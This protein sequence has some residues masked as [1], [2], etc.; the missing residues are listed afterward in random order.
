MKNLNYFNP[1]TRRS[2]R[3]NADPHRHHFRAGSAYVCWHLPSSEINFKRIQ[4]FRYEIQ[5]PL[6]PRLILTAPETNFVIC[7][8]RRNYV[9]C[10][11]RDMCSCNPIKP[12]WPPLKSYLQYWPLVNHIACTSAVNV[13]NGA[14]ACYSC[15]SRNFE[16]ASLNRLFCIF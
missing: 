7:R 6:S 9:N 4:N 12:F 1:S 15:S 11:Y 3:V 2:R 13:L 10:Q 8:C 16:N 14:A 5:C